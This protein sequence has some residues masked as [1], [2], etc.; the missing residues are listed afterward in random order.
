MVEH[1]RTEKLPI[2]LIIAKMN[3]GKKRTKTNII[4]L[5]TM[6]HSIIFILGPDRW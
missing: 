1:E 6:N 2:N 4:T 5:P 3:D